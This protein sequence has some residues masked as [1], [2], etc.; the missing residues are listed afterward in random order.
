MQ[1][2]KDKRWSTTQY[3]EVTNVSVSYQLQFSSKKMFGSFLR[4]IPL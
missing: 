4:R 2:P 1:R 3:I